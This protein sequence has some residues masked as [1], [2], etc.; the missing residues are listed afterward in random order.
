MILPGKHLR[1]ERSL[2]VLGAEVLVLLDEPA[3]ISE[4][5]EQ[6]KQYRKSAQQ[7]DV[8]FDWFVLALSFLFTVR[9]IEFRSGVIRRG[10]T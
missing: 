4:L 10:G 2:L 7:S 3:T 1:P 9:A 6:V 8:Q 5:W